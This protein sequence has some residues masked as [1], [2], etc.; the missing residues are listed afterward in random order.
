M[1]TQRKNRKN[2]RNSQ[3]KNRRNSQRGGF[4]GITLP[5][6][7]KWLGGPAPDG[8]AANKTDSADTGTTITT[9][10]ANSTGT[11]GTANN[12]DTGTTGTTD[13]ANNTGTDPANNTGTD[14]ANNTVTGTPGTTDS[15]NNTN[16]T[17]QL[18]GKSNKN[19]KSNKKRGGGLFSFGKSAK[20][21]PMTHMD[22][23]LQSVKE[24][25]K[26]RENESVANSKY[27]TARLA[28]YKRVYENATKVPLGKGKNK[29]R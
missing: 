7:P 14:P 25:K 1:P 22:I 2:R 6:L 15:T 23:K 19:K 11:T 29:K 8:A 9:D 24:A 10:P 16:T 3:R 12:T 13:P 4:L 27:D 26:Q 21:A 5:S 28:S 17:K 20:I 18:G